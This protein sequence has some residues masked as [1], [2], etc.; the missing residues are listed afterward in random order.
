[1]LSP[2]G[3]LVLVIVSVFVAMFLHKRQKEYERMQKDCE[4]I[5]HT[6]GIIVPLLSAYALS[7]Y[8]LSNGEIVIVF[9][10]IVFAL[11]H[12]MCKQS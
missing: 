12:L 11:F 10:N 3:M 2:D 8:S 1:M 5:P 6:F 4:K 9:L 7:K